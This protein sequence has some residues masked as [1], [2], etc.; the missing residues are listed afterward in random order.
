MRPNRGF[1]L[2]LLNGTACLVRTSL[3]THLSSHAP[4]AKDARVLTRQTSGPA[5]THSLPFF[6]SPFSVLF[7]ASAHVGVISERADCQV[8]QSGGFDSCS[9]LCVKGAARAV[10]SSNRFT[11]FYAYNFYEITHYFN[12]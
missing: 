2:L 5:E 6:P 3:G 1:I 9:D 4:C 11:R 12:N 8:N 7:S 10:L